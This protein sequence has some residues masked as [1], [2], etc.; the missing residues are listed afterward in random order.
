MELELTRAAGDGTSSCGL[1]GGAFWG[2]SETHM[3]RE[4]SAAVWAPHPDVRKGW[5]WAQRP[6][7]ERVEVH[8]STAAV[9][10]LRDGGQKTQSHIC[11]PQSAISVTAIVYGRFLDL[12]I[13]KPWSFYDKEGQ[14]IKPKKEKKKKTKVRYLAEEALYGT[15]RSH[16]WSCEGEA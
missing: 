4:S 6:F 14:A 9:S 8:E 11:A 2:R 3:P 5:R 7:S 1:C 12:C 16:Y 13:W 10:G 15:K